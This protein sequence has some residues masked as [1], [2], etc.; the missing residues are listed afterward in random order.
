MVQYGRYPSL[1]PTDGSH[2]KRLVKQPKAIFFQTQKIIALARSFAIQVGNSVILE[3]FSGFCT[4]SRLREY[5]SRQ[6]GGGMYVLWSS[7]KNFENLKI[8][9]AQHD[10]VSF[11]SRVTASCKMTNRNINPL[12]LFLIIFAKF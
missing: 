8:V 1:L 7:S 9:T 6:I 4:Q 3:F 5:F 10:V 11:L 12:F 2:F